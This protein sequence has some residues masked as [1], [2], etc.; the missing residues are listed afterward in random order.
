MVSKNL[1]DLMPVMEMCADHKDDKSSIIPFS[2]SNTDL[3]FLVSEDD[4]VTNSI[5][6][7][8]IYSIVF[9]LWHFVYKYVAEEHIFIY[10]GQVCKRSV[11]RIWKR[12][13]QNMHL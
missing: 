5:G 11:A 2:K 12:K 7:V 1:F 13:L 10:I 9:S 6:Q 8:I 3:L 4:G